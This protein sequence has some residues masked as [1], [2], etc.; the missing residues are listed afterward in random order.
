MLMKTWLLFLAVG[1]L[2]AISPGP[3]VLL[4]ISNALRYGPRA[5]LYSA[6]GNALG[7]T[8]LGFAVAFGLAAVLAVSAAA[9]TVVK[10]I[11]AAYLVYL[12]AKL[13]RDGKAI[14]LDGGA[15]RPMSGARLFRQAFFVSVTNPK[16]LVLIAAL[17]PPFVDR[18]QPMITQVAIMSVSYAALCFANHLMLAVAGGRLRRFLSSEKRMKAVR[19]VLGSMFIGFGAALAAASR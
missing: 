12:G 1:I 2:P 11:G 10:I 19:R 16:A 9:F 4:A 6:L 7:L 14:S 17:I 15:S 18:G 3:A 13:W 8:I 5:V